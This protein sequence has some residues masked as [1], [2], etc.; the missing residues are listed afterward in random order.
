MSSAAPPRPPR[1]DGRATISRSTDAVAIPSP[2]DPLFL[3][4]RVVAE[5]KLP[6][7]ELW[8]TPSPCPLPER[9]GSFGG[10]GCA[11]GAAML[12]PARHAPRSPARTARRQRHLW[13]TADLRRDLG[14]ARQGRSR[15]PGRAQ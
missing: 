2:S 3:R 4:E 11:G 13:R 15:L 5:R 6:T 1:G 9:E 14:R 10:A 12:S 8:R 7:I